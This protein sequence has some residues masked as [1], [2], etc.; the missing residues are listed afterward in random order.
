M[1][2]GVTCLCSYMIGCPLVDEENSST[3]HEQEVTQGANSLHFHQICP[4]R[5]VL[6]LTN[7]SSRSLNQVYSPC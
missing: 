7:V 5:T 6:S 1:S 2:V 3:S 4:Q